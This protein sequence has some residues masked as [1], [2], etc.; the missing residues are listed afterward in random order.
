MT[1][2]FQTGETI[3]VGHNIDA[4]KLRDLELSRDVP[5]IVKI[6]ITNNARL[7]IED[8]TLPVLFDSSTPYPG[9][10]VEGKDFKNDIVWLGTSDK[11][12]GKS[13][14]LLY[15]VCPIPH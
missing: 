7:K 2:L 9:K 8:K 6:T 11:V 4:Y 14:Q 10:V 1:P 5:Y 15:F 13:V 3:R 12:Q